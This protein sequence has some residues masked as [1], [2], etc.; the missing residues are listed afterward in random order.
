MYSPREISDDTKWYINENYFQ[1]PGIIAIGKTSSPRKRAA[2]L[3]LD[4]R[5]D[6]IKV[7]DL[8]NGAVAS[9]AASAPSSTLS[10]SAKHGASSA[11]DG[12]D[13]QIKVT[14]LANGAVANMAASI[15]RSASPQTP[16]E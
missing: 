7:A 11:S 3:T 12:S 4:A 14:D 16:T 5:D 13:D 9:M 8:A 10:Q 1:R 6:Q 2:T 15:R